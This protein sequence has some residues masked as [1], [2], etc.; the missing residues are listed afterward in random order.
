MVNTITHDV[1]GNLEIEIEDGIL[2]I[3]GETSVG[4]KERIPLHITG[5][6]GQTSDEILALALGAH[7]IFLAREIEFRTATVTAV[8]TQEQVKKIADDIGEELSMD[9]IV[10]GYAGIM[11]INYFTHGNEVSIYF[12]DEEG[13]VGMD[14]I[15]TSDLGFTNMGSG[16]DG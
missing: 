4:S 6:V 11:I 16:S 8:V 5:R 1:F 3:N 13:L 10:D 12:E 15:L 2:H 14:V 7:Q 9:D